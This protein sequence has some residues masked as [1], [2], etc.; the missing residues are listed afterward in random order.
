[1]VYRQD[2]L[3]STASAIATRECTTLNAESQLSK[4]LLS[5]K[6][7]E[8]RY[9]RHR[10]KNETAHFEYGKV[11]TCRFTTDSISFNTV[12]QAMVP[13]AWSFFG[14]IPSLSTLTG[15]WDNY[16]RQAYK[17]LLKKADRHEHTSLALPLFGSGKAR[18]NLHKAIDPLVS[19]LE[20]LRSY[21][22]NFPKYLRIIEIYTIKEEAYSLLTDRLQQC[23]GS[24]DPTGHPGRLP[25]SASSTDTESDL[26]SYEFSASPIATDTKYSAM[27]YAE[28]DVKQNGTRREYKMESSPRGIALIINN[29][30][31]N[32]SEKFT[33]RTGTQTDCGKLCMLFKDRLHFQVEVLQDLTAQEMQN[34]LRAFSQDQALSRVDSMMVAVLSHG[35]QGD[36]I[37]G[38]DGH[39]GVDGKPEP[40]TYIKATDIQSFFT[41]DNCP[42]MKDKPKLFIGQ[43]CRGGREHT[44][45]QGVMHLGAVARDIVEENCTHAC[46]DMYF[47]YATVPTYVAYRGQFIQ[48]LCEIFQRY[49][50]S[51]HIKDMATFMHDKMAQ[52]ELEKGH[53]TISEDRGTLRKHWFF[54]PP[55]H[56][57]VA[58]GSQA[59]TLPPALF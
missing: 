3:L 36:I 29:E 13:S 40:G 14:I 23:F 5:R 43:F 42:A 2:M 41:S 22:R 19:C 37:Y 39:L 47:L 59:R 7:D 53:L 9:A 8:Y 16:A 54:H 6:P 17:E 46:A 10:L 20:H 12:Y 35:G 28:E 58:F 56:M 1:M 18:A 45:D 24:D 33:R 44:L 49:A 11:Y 50:D 25:V 34:E 51:H 38:I 57:D 32:Q 52:K 31:F 15:K 55:P 21:G 27:D 26:S 48:V 4:Q 30:K